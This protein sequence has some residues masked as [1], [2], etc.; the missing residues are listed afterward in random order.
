MRSGNREILLFITVLAISLIGLYILGN[1]TS[2]GFD[3]ASDAALQSAFSARQ[4]AQFNPIAIAL[5]ASKTDGALP[6]N[7][8]PLM[9]T[10]SITP[11]LSGGSTVK[12]DNPYPQEVDPNGLLA[13]IKLC[14]GVKTVDANAFNDPNF[15]ANCGI[16]VDIGKNSAG[17]PTKGGLVLLPKDKEYAQKHQR[18]DHLPDYKPTIGTCPA[19]RMA[20]NAAEVRRIQNI[21]SCQNSAS[22]DITGC[23]QCYADQSYFPVEG[24]TNV[25]PPAIY[26]AG[27]GYLTWYET[28]YTNGAGVNL[29]GSPQKLQLKGPEATRVTL[30]VSPNN[31]NGCYIAGYLEG[32]TSNGYFRVDLQRIVQTDG[33][34]GRKPRLTGPVTINGVSCNNMSPGFGQENMNLIIPTP[35]TFVDTTSLSGEMCST[36]PFVTKQSS[37]EFLASDPC[38]KKGSGPGNYNQE[39]LQNSFY[40]NGCL[41]SGKGFPMSTTA[42]AALLATPSG[43]NRSLGQISEFIYENAIRSATGMTSGGAKLSIDD[44]SAASEFCTGRKIT[45]PCDTAAKDTGPL[46]GDCLT[47]LWRNQ[48]N[49][50]PLGATYKSNGTF[51]SLFS[52]NT[53]QFCTSS[54]TL[55]PVDA[56]GM[57]NQAAIDYWRKQG[58]VNNVKNLMDQLHAL[59]SQPLSD[60]SRNDAVLKCYGKNLANRPVPSGAAVSGQCSAS[61]GVKARTVRI[62]QTPGQYLHFSQVAVMDANGINVAKGKQASVQSTW[63]GGD[64]QIP[65]DG[66]LK[67]RPW[68]QNWH[69]GPGQTSG[70]TWSV[71]LG[72]NY[73]IVRVVVFQ[74]TDCCTERIKGA[75]VSLIDE[76]GR[77]VANQTINST[78]LVL[79]LDFRKAGASDDCKACDTSKKNE[80]FWIARGNTY[81]HAKADAEG[82][83]NA[84]GATNATQSQLNSAQAQGADVCASGWVKDNTN[85]VYPISA[86]IDGGCGN[87][88]TGIMTYTPANKT[89]GVWCYGIKPL[90]DSIEGDARKLSLDAN[91]PYYIRNFDQTRYSAPGAPAGNS[92]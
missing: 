63:P 41:D 7:T 56:N 61:C 54:G 67:P 89:A 39:C 73:D 6:A 1:R 51:S 57:T 14:E 90:G 65:L 26:V 69:I 35:F 49:G 84:V 59:A 2:E 43:Y 17:N 29:N 86:S 82:V 60:P 33:W 47:Y 88:T 3:A 37:A 5:A 10:S 45:S 31:P 81:W 22:Y 50:K 42:N 8:Q 87:G 21:M 16:C 38:Y 77:I 12:M 24:T 66:V 92:I 76:S 34:T 53:V 55:S 18:G 30:N 23:S 78:G 83:C 15:A 36:G 13:M 52:D 40:S 62:L 11:T 46:S 20:G 19:Q 28:G 58:G 9:G 64:P 75:V 74:R 91:T 79:P 44:W 80:V 72:A 32:V 25:N 70:G 85:A 68:N 48:G 71:D 27:S 4:K